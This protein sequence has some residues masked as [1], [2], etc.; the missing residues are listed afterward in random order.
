[1]SS[2]ITV[3][4]SAD[5]T[6][7]EDAAK[8]QEMLVEEG[9][10]ATL[11]NDE[12][13]EVPAG[14]YEVQVDENNR[15]RAEELVA[16]YA[17]EREMEE[18]DPSHALDLVTVFRAGGPTGEMEAMSVQS[19]LEAEGI[20]AMIVGDSRYPNFPQEVRVAQEHET[21]ARQLIE[22][23]LAAGPVGAEEAEQAGESGSTG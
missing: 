6:A 19:V 11:L 16:Q 12:A 23:A 2:Q 14:A 7:A 20:S 9:I 10:P 5:E 22:E 21:R 4:R 13:P 3:F 8:V 15:A 17:P 18:V 1:M